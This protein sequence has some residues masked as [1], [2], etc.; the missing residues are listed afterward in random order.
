MAKRDRLQVLAKEKA[1]TPEQLIIQA[2]KASNGSVEKAAQKLGV[3][4]NTVSTFLKR[5]GLE[6]RVTYR[7]S[8]VKKKE[9][10]S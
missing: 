9:V 1:T 7:V 5:Q 4:R 10:K 3:A 6:V 8:V 2:I